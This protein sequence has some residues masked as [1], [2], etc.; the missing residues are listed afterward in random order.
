MSLIDIDAADNMDE[1]PIVGLAGAHIAQKIHSMLEA[2]KI[3]LP[4]SGTDDEHTLNAIK[5]ALSTSVL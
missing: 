5:V 1:D 2:T 4:W 3:L